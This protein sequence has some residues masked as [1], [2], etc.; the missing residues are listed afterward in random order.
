[1]NTLLHS[2]GGGHSGKQSN[3]LLGLAGQVLGGGKHS[4]SQQSSNAGTA[5]IIGAVAG[6][7]LGGGKTNPNQ[8]PQQSYSGH[9]PQS[10]YGHQDG[11]MGKLGGMF[12]GTNSGHV[13][14][15]LTFLKIEAY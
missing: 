2:Q 7:L 5:G 14:H 6:S 4:Q 9:T 13:R 15:C 10:A 8:A 1:M 11:L 3:P 12:G